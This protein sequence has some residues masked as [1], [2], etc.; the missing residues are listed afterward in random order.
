VYR[1]SLIV[2][3]EEASVIHQSMCC[4]YPSQSSQIDRC[5][6]S[7]FIFESWFKLNACLHSREKLLP[8]MLNVGRLVSRLW[9]SSRNRS[10]V[11][12]FRDNLAKSLVIL[13]LGRFC[14]FQRVRFTHLSRHAYNIRT[15]SAFHVNHVHKIGIW[16]EITPNHLDISIH[17]RSEIE[18]Y[19]IDSWRI[20]TESQSW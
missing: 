6:T 14:S 2:S 4:M 18:A 9:W 13:V 20:W 5:G 15:Q 12:L 8:R 3:A 11:R 19:C 1:Q 7:C 10:I 17:V 16:V